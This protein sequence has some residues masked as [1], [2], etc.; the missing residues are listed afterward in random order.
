MTCITGLF[1]LNCGVSCFFNFSTIWS[2]GNVMA[3][4]FAIFHGSLIFLVSNWRY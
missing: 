3:C 1:V 4:N 2:R